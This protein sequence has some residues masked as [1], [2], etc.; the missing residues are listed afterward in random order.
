MDGRIRADGAPTVK[1]GG[2]VHA[3]ME[4]LSAGQFGCDELFANIIFCC[5]PR[6]RAI[7]QLKILRFS[8]LHN[9]FDVVNS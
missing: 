7:K 5:F 2:G 3:K 9:L 6:A 4:P 1:Q 8:I